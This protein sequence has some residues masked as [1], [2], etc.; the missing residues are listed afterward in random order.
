[1]LRATSPLLLI[2]LLVAGC[3]GGGGAAD[4]DPASAVPRDA[5]LYLEAAVRPEG[6]TREHALAAAG[7][8]LRT[9]DPEAK[10]RELLHRALADDAGDV[11]YDRDIGPWLG[12]RAGLWVSD[13]LDEN[14]EPGVAAAVAATDLDA[15]ESAIEDSRRRNGESATERSHAGVE[16]RVDADGFAYA[17]AEDFVLFGD[18]PELKR[19][20]DALEGEAL[21]SDQRYRDAI[22][23]LSDDRLAH[24]F[25]D[26][27]GFFAFVAQTDPESA[28]GLR[29]LQGLIPF[30]RLP[31]AAGAFLADGDR[32]AID[33]STTIPWGDLRRRLGAVA[34]GTGTTPLLRELPGDSWGAQG[35]PRFGETMRVLFDQLAGA[36]GGAVVEEQ[37]RSELGL[38]LEQDVFSWVG[39]IALFIRGESVDA[40][41]GGVV[42]QVTD[43]D[44]AADAFGKI[45]GALRARGQLDAQPLRLEG[46]ETAFAVA[47]GGAPRPIVFARG[48]GKVVVTYGEEAAVAA[49]DPGETL[50][51]S[52]LF[53]RAESVLGDDL[54]PSMLLSIP[55]VVALVDSSGS[56]DPSWDQAKPYIE[57]FDVIAIGGGTDGARSRGRVAAGLR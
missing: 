48:D 31:P 9:P 52:E 38:D 25:I 8:V 55:P 17:F 11:D 30:D 44:R 45:V 26:T 6:D 12:E 56:A 28:E 40:L 15:A 57:A 5:L 36:F 23:G 1:M 51:D 43:E 10:I 37:L 14:E 20:I 22:E 7:K 13:R 2:V 4:A 19:T 21:D 42:I 53:S 16:Y 24:F 34:W 33:L 50:G 29:Q 49:L 27:K 39:D 46:A 18:E 54:E 32:L 47:A 3:G 35:A 41:D